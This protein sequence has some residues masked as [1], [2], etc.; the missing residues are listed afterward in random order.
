M[1]WK[2]VCSMPVELYPD[3]THDVNQLRKLLRQHREV[4]YQL[5]TGGGKTV[6]AGH[7]MQRARSRGR[8]VLV[9]VHRRE[10][11]RQFVDTLHKAGLDSDVGVV[12]SGYTPTPWAP[13]QVAMVFSWHRRDVKFEPDIIVVD[14]A[15]HVKA[16]ST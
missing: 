5:S 15:H 13:I 16:K 11:V 12:C 8:K 6:V 10:L 3:Q 9:L 4:L 7:V 2:T 1:Q 14:E